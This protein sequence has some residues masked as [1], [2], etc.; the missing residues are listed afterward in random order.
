[1]KL[2][3]FCFERKNVKFVTLPTTL[4]TAYERVIVYCATW[5]GRVHEDFVNNV[6]FSIK[7]FLSQNI[8][9]SSNFARIGQGNSQ[10]S[11]THCVRFWN[12]KMMIQIVIFVAFVSIVNNILANDQP[13]LKDCEWT[14]L[15][16]MGYLLRCPYLEI[17]LGYNILFRFQLK[18]ASMNPR[19]R[20]VCA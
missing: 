4:L 15:T 7:E 18:F 14:D 5:Y 20:R 17:N 9:S 2:P 6:F 16:E 13:Q 1:M 3:L 8:T 11:T 12:I 19:T 10:L